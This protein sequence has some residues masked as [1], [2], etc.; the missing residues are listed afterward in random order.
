M[1]AFRFYDHK[2]KPSEI[3]KLSLKCKKYCALCDDYLSK[4]VDDIRGF[5]SFLPIC[6]IRGPSQCFYINSLMIFADDITISWTFL[7]KK[8]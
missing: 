5:N 7:S 6:K 4:F 2:A 3:N 1:E 8:F